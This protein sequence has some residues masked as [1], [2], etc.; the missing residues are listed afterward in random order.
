MKKINKRN[1]LIKFF[2]RLFNQ[3][4]STCTVCGLPYNHC[5]IKSIDINESD[6]LF[7]TCDYC[8]NKT[9]LDRL[10]TIYTNLYIKVKHESLKIDTK[11]SYTLPDVIYAVENEYY[12]THRKPWNGRHCVVCGSI[13]DFTCCSEQCFHIYRKN[14]IIYKEK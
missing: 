2:L 1:P 10:K 6:G 13:S 5:T 9:S 12:K 8:W 3:N 7:A 4:R 11:L 14:E